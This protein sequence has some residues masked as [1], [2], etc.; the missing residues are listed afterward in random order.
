MVFKE[1]QIGRLGGVTIPE[2]RFLPLFVY[3]LLLTILLLT[4]K[5]NFNL[6]GYSYYLDEKTMMLTIEEGFGKIETYNVQDSPIQAMKVMISINKAYDMWGVTILI[7]SLF[8]TGFFLL[9]VKPG[10]PRKIVKLYLTIYFIFLTVFIFWSI[11][12]HKEI[13]QEISNALNNL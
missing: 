8:I 3:I 6:T 9:F 10:I 7:S 11:Y 5:T 12:R 13:I 1:S 2:K 4:L